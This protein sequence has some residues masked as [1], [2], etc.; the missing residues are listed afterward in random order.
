MIGDKINRD[1]IIV[2]TKDK[3]LPQKLQLDVELTLEKAVI[4]VRQYKKV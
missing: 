4:R 2:G 3:I 1:K